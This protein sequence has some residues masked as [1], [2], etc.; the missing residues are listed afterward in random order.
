M[1]YKSFNDW[2]AF[3]AE[4]LGKVA[5]F[6]EGNPTDEAL[7][8]V[9]VAVA[10]V[11]DVAKAWQKNPADQRKIEDGLQAIFL[12]AVQFSRLIRRQ[13]ALWS[14]RFPLGPYGGGPGPLKFEPS[15]MKNHRV[16]DDDDDEGGRKPEQRFVEYVI[17]PALFKRGTMD[18]ERY[19]SEAAIVVAEVGLA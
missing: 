19:D 3:T 10:D 1:P 11:M 8:L 7:T 6:P 17:T 18:G 16:E 2:R 4:L 9:G 12:R 14:V 15:S 5:A 13:R